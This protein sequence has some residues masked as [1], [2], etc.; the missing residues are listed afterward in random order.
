MIGLL[1]FFGALVLFVLPG[2]WIAFGDRGTTLTLRVRLSLA[3]VLSPLVVIL[4]FYVLRFAGLSFDRTAVVLP[5]LNLPAAWLVA[6]HARGVMLP[7]SRSL[8][9]W[10]AMLL[11]V[12][13]FLGLFMRTSFVRTNLAHAWLHTGIVYMV[14]N[15]QLRPEEPQLAGIRLS[16]PWMSHIYQGVVSFLLSSSPNSSY[17]LT[18]VIWLLAVIALVAAIVESFGGDRLAQ[19]MSAVF[20]TFGANSVGYVAERLVPLWIRDGYP[21]WGDARYTPWLRKFAMFQQAVFGIGVFAALAFMLT[22]DTEKP[23]S[24]SSLLL[25]GA[26]LLSASLLY[27]LLCPASLAL[28]GARVLVLIVRRVQRRDSR[29]DSEIATLLLIATVAAVVLAA[30]VSLVTLDRAGDATLGLSDIRNV[31]M[32]AATS[33]LV[34]APLLL[35]LALSARPL[36]RAKPDSLAV[37]VF[38]ALASAGAY[39]ALDIYYWS[40]EYKYM[41]TAAICLAPLAAIAFGQVA[42]KVGKAAIPAAVALSIALVLPAL[43]RVREDKLHS[44]AWRQLDAGRFDLR[45]APIERYAKLTDAIRVSTPQTAVLVSRDTLFDWVAVTRRAVYVPFERGW[46]HGFGMPAEALLKQLRGYPGAV[47]DRRRDALGQ[48]YEGRDASERARAARQILADLGRP[49]VIMTRRTEDADLAAWL[50]TWH[51]ARLVYSARTEAAW[52]VDITAP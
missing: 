12:A 15:G 43:Y 2:S 10:S 41:F 24:K 42:S 35:G 34:L 29:A 19:G 37:L 4:E 47:V 9:L 6:R 3:V 30:H 25:V 46:V 49:I 5:L 33:V 27:P 51:P 16:Y 17:I 13:A 36:W 28:V 18:N 22:R 21:I 31:M 14:A 23:L 20:L 40:N 1:G 11:P 26:L 32:K 38:G 52:L 50:A 7:R 39:V 45:L 44:A 48:L 8:A